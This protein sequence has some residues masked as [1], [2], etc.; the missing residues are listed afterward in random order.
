MFYNDAHVEP[1]RDGKVQ[2]TFLGP[3]GVRAFTMTPENAAK[4]AN[5]LREAAKRNYK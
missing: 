3:E 4:F 5:A 1:T 2:V